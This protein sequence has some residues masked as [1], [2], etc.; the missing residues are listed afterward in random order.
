MFGV[1]SAFTKKYQ[2]NAGD[3]IKSA[4]IYN[5]TSPLLFI[6]IMFIY[7][8]GVLSCTLFSFV[9][10]V[11][12]AVLCNAMSF[13]QIKALSHG[14]IANYSLFLLG[15]GMIL[16]IVYGIICGEAFSAFKI[17]GIILVCVAIA[18]KIDVKEKSDAKTLGCLILIFILNGLFG[19]LS[20]IYQS[21]LFAFEKVSSEQF[22]VLRGIFT[23]ALGGIMYC[24]A[25]LFYKDNKAETKEV[26]SKSYLKAMPWSLA[27]GGINGIANL[28]LLIS[29]LTVPA[30]LQYPIITGGGIFISAVVGLC[31]KEK[32]TLKTWLSVAFAVIGTIVMVF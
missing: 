26:N 17:A 14:N 18:I 12:W 20:A 22:S 24:F 13:F 2:K 19:V 10:A 11:I 25:A 15:G 4:F 31:F 7:N 32:T 29:L 1:Q 28:L 6:V 30:S 5:A 3:G 21:D 8:G 23:A 16:P 27:G 9:M